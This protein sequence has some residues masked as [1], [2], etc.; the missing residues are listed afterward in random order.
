MADITGKA[1]PRLSNTQAR[2]LFL[3]RHGL[4]DDPSR[5][6]GRG[7]LQTLIE[8]LGFVQVDSINTVARAHDLILFSRRQCYR[9]KQLKTL[10][11]KERSLFEHWT[12]D[13]SIIPS[14]FYPYWELRFERYRERLIERWRQWRQEGFEEKIDDVLAHIERNGPAMS[15]EMGED[16][17]KNN[18]GW[19]DWHPSKTALE[20]LWRTGQ[21]AVCR[22]EGF[23]KVYDLSERVIGEEHRTDRYSKAETID[24][25][26]SSALDRLGFATSGEIAAFWD[27]ITPAEAKKWCVDRLGSELIEMEIETAQGGRPHRVFA[28]AGIE[29]ELDRLAEP[30][31][32]I[33]VLSPF[34][35]AI[36]DRKRAERLFGFN[37]RIEVFVPAAKRRYGYY[38]FPLLEGDRLIGRIDMK[39]RGDAGVLDVTA[40]WPEPK[41]KLG[42]GRL[43]RLEAELDRIRRFAGCARIDYADGWIREPL[44]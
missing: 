24:W 1:V 36:R 3:E 2:R 38:V 9:P 32:R 14:R 6:V 16:E 4:C 26:C 22:R 17:K 10:L 25:A 34:D 33:R 44:P 15:R 35:P 23:Q 40:F 31:G 27:G 39:R 21:L 11:E 28:R 43:A 12:H 5:K 19:W 29:A 13:A 41:V 7:E 30:P 8:R 42:R 18:G 20:Y 37:Y